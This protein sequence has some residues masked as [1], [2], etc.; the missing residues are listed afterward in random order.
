[1]NFFPLH[2]NDYDQA[3]AHLTAI[4]DGILGRLIRRY[5][6]TE[7]PLVADIAA[8]K[9][10]VRA[11]SRQEQE[12]VDTVLP[13]FFELQEDGWHQRR[14]DAELAQYQAKQEKSKRS[15]HAR[16]DAQRQHTEGNADAMP[17]QCE[18]NADAMRTHSEGNADAMRTQCEGNA[19][20]ARPM[21]HKPVTNNQKKNTGATAPTPD[22]VSAEVWDDFVRMRK[23]KRAPI[24]S[25][26]IQGIEREA[27]KAS[28]TLQ[29]AL[30]MACARGWQGFKAEWAVS[31]AGQTAANQQR[32]VAAAAQESHPDSKASIE[33]LALAKGLPTWNGMEQWSIY[34][35]RVRESQVVQ[36]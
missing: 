4:E 30:A 36:H 28:M 34:A 2:I 24:T 6:A 11:H 9:R 21:N 18:G 29:D 31:D 15:A 14:C 8:L 27:A 26:A 12:A 7:R 19:T 3:T 13:E 25:T 17:N 1:V 10:L 23:A 20:R 35:A 33:A 22:G 16:W 32:G 5:Y